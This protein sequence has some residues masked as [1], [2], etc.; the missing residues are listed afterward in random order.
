MNVHVDETSSRLLGYTQCLVCGK[1]FSSVTCLRRHMQ[2]HEAISI[3]YECPMCGLTR[4]ENHSCVFTCIDCDTP[5]SSKHSLLLHRKLHARID[6]VKSTIHS[7]SDI[8][9]LQQELGVYQI[10]K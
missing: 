2:I 3:G 4:G 9:L 10:S 8:L 6:M 5:F 7:D 1:E